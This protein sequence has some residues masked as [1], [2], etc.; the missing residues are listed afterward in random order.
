MG[1]DVKRWDCVG[2]GGGR[3]MGMHGNVWEAC[4]GRVMGIHGT[5][6]EGCGGKDVG[7]DVTG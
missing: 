2:R 3:V 5:V 4:G 6:W 7:I 1:E